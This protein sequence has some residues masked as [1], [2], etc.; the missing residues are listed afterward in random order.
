[1]TT[2]QDLIIRQGETWSFVWTKRDAAGAAVDLTGYS[3]RMAIRDRIGGA[4]LQALLSST[5]DTGGTITLGGAAGTVT[6]S[7]TAAQSAVLAA[8]MATLSV[9]IAAQEPEGLAPTET[10]AY[11]LQ[12][13][14]PAGVVTRDLEGQVVVH[15]RVTV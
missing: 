10:Y 4:N 7:M 3:A 11:D 13:T 6:M 14:S 15:R 5:G 9:M 1:M 8:T 12:L 2:R